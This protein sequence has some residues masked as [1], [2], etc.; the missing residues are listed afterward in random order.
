ME[1]HE[2][3]PKTDGYFNKYNDSLD[4][5]IS[6]AFAT[7]AFRFGH[8]LLPNLIKILGND[9]ASFEYVQMHKMLLDPFKLYDRTAIDKIII[10]ASNTHIERSDSYFSTE[11]NYVTLLIH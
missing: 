3:L 5:S 8:S 1:K 7:A 10:G 11:V 4:A 6:N 2:L 9:N